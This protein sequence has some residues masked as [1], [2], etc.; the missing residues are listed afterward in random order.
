MTA[1]DQKRSRS[2]A[3][4]ASH[5]EGAEHLALGGSEI[6]AKTAQ[7]HQRYFEHIRNIESF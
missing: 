5:S 1:R 3:I 6:R 4:E 7:A 2:D